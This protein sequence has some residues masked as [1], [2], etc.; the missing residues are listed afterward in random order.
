MWTRMHE[1]MQAECE[2]TDMQ[3]CQHARRA[4]KHTTN[5]QA[6]IW[7]NKIIGQCNTRATPD[8]QLFSTKC[9]TVQNHSDND[10]NMIIMIMIMIMIMIIF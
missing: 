2:H 9:W 3:A 5:M 1:I 8:Q 7:S 10:T 4:R 6:V